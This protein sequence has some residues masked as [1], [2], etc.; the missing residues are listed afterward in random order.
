[1]DFNVKIISPD[2][3]RSHCLVLAVFESRK[4]SD[5]AARVDELS[6]GHIA[7]TLRQGDIS[8]KAGETLLLY[9]VP[10]VAAQRV[11]LVGCGKH[12][13]VAKSDYL[14]AIEA[15]ISLLQAG[16]SQDAVSAL[17]EVEIKDVNM[18]WKVRQHVEAAQAAVYRFD[19]LK[20]EV[21]PPKKA[22]GKLTLSVAQ[23]R[24]LKTAQ[25]AVE[26]GAAI[27]AGVAF[28]KD[29][30]N[31]PGN[32]CTPTHLAEQ[33]QELAKGNG[34]LKV[35][36]LNEAEIK[37]LGMGSF[38]SV[39]K[40]SRQPPKLI[41]LQYNGGK[42]GDK[43]VVLVGKGI[44]FDS[45]GVSIKPS[46]AMDEMKYDMG[47]AASVLGTFKAISLIK[48]AINV[49]GIIPSCEN[50]PDGA[51]N[52][53]GDIVTSMSGQTIEVLNTDAEGRL[54]L[55]DALTYSER[56]DPA[57]VIDIATL[58][59]ACVIALGAHASGLLSNNRSLAAHLLK[60][61]EQANDRAWELPLW[62]DYQQQLKSNFADMANIGGREAGTITAACFLSRFAKKLRWAHLD[63]A[64]TAWKG[65]VA[66]GATGR[67]VPLLSQYILD[68]APKRA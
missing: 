40:G 18:H 60:S 20:S 68:R 38:L 8:G 13:H 32:I 58:T 16:G 22:L 46:P 24:D 67:P 7:R 5:M 33:A 52:K 41:V 36:V 64:G 6:G 62:E 45:G 66:K 10:G 63:I 53:P 23:R 42:K 12:N 35:E 57:V 9:Q 49:V 19:E 25:A 3:Q 26:E 14:K 17:T 47:G 55:C 15:A 56:F 2:S 29:L 43:P 1:M 44:T 11:L 28:T 21:E 37:K 4:L 39:A 51:A 50:M 59:G 65:G 54:I 30:A 27:A 61:G 34:K 31:R 48:P